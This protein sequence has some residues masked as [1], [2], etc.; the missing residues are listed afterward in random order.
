MKPPTNYHAIVAAGGWN[1][2]TAFLSAK[3]KA[4]ARDSKGRFIPMG[5]MVRWMTQEGMR[6]G[7]VVGKSADGK[8]ISVQENGKSVVA[9]VQPKQLEVVKALIPSNQ[10]EAKQLADAQDW[11]KKIADAGG[12]PAAP[13][14][15]VSPAQAK[16]SLNEE[17]AEQGMGYTADDELIKQL[18]MDELDSGEMGDTVTIK[19]PSGSEISMSEDAASAILGWDNPTPG[20]AAKA[21][22]PDA[23]PKVSIKAEDLSPD[24][25]PQ[26]SPLYVD[27]D[28]FKKVG[29]QAGSNAGGVYEAPDGTRYYVKKAQTEQHAANEVLAA[30]LYKD[31]GVTLPEIYLTEFPDG[32]GPAVASKMIDGLK[33]MF[34]N[35]QTTPIRLGKARAGFAMDAWLSNWD[36]VG[37]EYDNLMMDADQNPVRVDPGGALLYRAMGSPKGGLFSDTVGETETLRDAGMNP[38]AAK[39]FGGMSNQDISDAIAATVNKVDLDK[40]NALI[41]ELPFSSDAIRTDLKAKLKNRKADL[42]TKFNVPAAKIGHNADDNLATD[43][44]KKSISDAAD[45]FLADGPTAKTPDAPDFSTK[46]PHDPYGYTEMTAADVKAGDWVRYDFGYKNKQSYMALESFKPGDKYLTVS[47]EGSLNASQIPVSAGTKLPVYKPPV[48]GTPVPQPVEKNLDG[49]IPTMA[50][51][52]NPGDLIQVKGD[53][54]VELDSKFST[55]KGVTGTYVS[56]MLSGGTFQQKAHKST[57][58]SKLDPE[59]DEYK[60][61]KA[62]S[63]KAPATP[64]DEPTPEPETSK[65]APEITN[66]AFSDQEFDALDEYTGDAHGPINSYLRTGLAHG[67]DP[68]D[69]NALVDKLDTA[70]AKS[71]VQNDS[72]VYRGISDEDFDLEPGSIMHDDGFVSTSSSLE[73]AKEFSK[74]GKGPGAVFEIDLPKG[75]NAVD[76]TKAGLG[77]YGEKEILLNRDSLFE[78]TDV[79]VLADGKKYIKATYLLGGPGAGKPKPHAEEV[80]GDDAEGAPA[81]APGAPGLDGGPGDGDASAAGGLGEAELLAKLEEFRAEATSAADKVQAVNLKAGKGGILSKDEI[82]QSDAAYKKLKE[83]RAQA[84]PFLDALWAQKK[85]DLP[86]LADPDEARWSGVT[87]LAKGGLTQVGDLDEATWDKYRDMYVV[88]DPKTLQHNSSLRSDAPA[89]ASKAWAAKVDKLV[90]QH[91]LKEDSLLY[92]GGAFSPEF[93]ATLTPG[94]VLDDKGF[95]S[96]GDLNDAHFYGENRAAMKPGTKH[97]VF[98]IQVHAGQS[99]TDVG[100]GEYVLPR[101]SKML[102]K[103]VREGDGSGGDANKEGVVYL[104]A[105]LA[106]NGDL[107]KVKAHAGTGSDAAEEVTPAV[108]K[109]KAS[110]GSMKPASELKPGDV[111]SPIGSKKKSVITDVQPTASGSIAVTFQDTNKPTPMTLELDPDDQNTMGLVLHGGPPKP[112]P[113][114]PPVAKGGDDDIPHPAAKI[115][116]VVTSKKDGFSGTVIKVNPNSGYSLVLSKDGSKKLWRKWDTLE[117][118]QDEPAPAPELDDPSQDDPV[119]EQVADLNKKADA[120]SEALAEFDVPADLAAQHMGE[121]TDALNAIADG[122]LQFD[123]WAI[124]K[125]MADEW[126]GGDDDSKGGQLGE[127][128]AEL[129]AAAGVTD[130]DIDEP[131]ATDKLLD[132]PG[133]GAQSSDED[134][135][136]MD[137]PAHVTAAIH[138]NEAM[139]AA[140]L[141]HFGELDPNDDVETKKSWLL[142]ALESLNE[143]DVTLSGPELEAFQ[144]LADALG[145][146]MPEQ[147]KMSPG[148]TNYSVADAVIG[149][150][151]LYNGK[152]VEIALINHSLGGGSTSI[153]ITPV[154]GGTGKFIYVNE[155]S[156]LPVTKKTPKP[157]LPV[158]TTMAL[159]PGDTVAGPG[160]KPWK[161]TLAEYDSG[162]YLVAWESESGTTHQNYFPANSNWDVIAE[163]PD[164][165]DAPESESESSVKLPTKPATEIN[166]GDEITIGEPDYQ[167]HGTVLE[168]NV[169]TA[170]NVVLL[171]EVPGNPPAEYI[172]VP[173]EQATINKTAL[174]DMGD[175]EGTEFV[176][177]T[178]LEEGDLLYNEDSE[179]LGTVANIHYNEDSGDYDIQYWDANGQEKTYAGAASWGQ[180]LVKKGAGTIQTPAPTPDKPQV[181]PASELKAGDLI[182]DVDGDT[183]H[184]ESVEALPNGKLKISYT[185]DEYGDQI[186]TMDIDPSNT[187]WFKKTG[188]GDAPA[189]ETTPAKKVKDYKPGDKVI[190][191][192][193]PGKIG[194]SEQS[195]FQE[196]GEWFLTVDF[197]DGAYD[198]GWVSNNPDGT[199]KFVENEDY[200]DGENITLTP[201]DAPQA[202]TPTAHKVG[203]TP[204]ASEYTPGMVLQTGT[205]SKNKY[206]VNSV[207]PFTATGDGQKKV[208]LNLTDVDSGEVFPSHT[209]PADFTNWELIELPDAPAGPAVGDKITPNQVK[210]GMTIKHMSGVD[211]EVISVAP[212]NNDSSATLHLKGVEDGG[213]FP[214]YVM[215]N[216]SGAW[217]LVANPESGPVFPPLDQKP[218]S[219]PSSEIAPGDIIWNGISTKPLAKLLSK[220]NETNS[221]VNWNIEGVGLWA[222]ETVWKMG[223]LDSYQVAK[224]G[225]APGVPESA[226]E[227]SAPEAPTGTLVAGSS[228]V[229]QDA[230]G[231]YV[232]NKQGHVLREGDKVVT[233]KGE[234]GT[235]SKFELDAKY[236]KVKIDGKTK[237]RQI[238]TLSPAAGTATPA[239]TPADVPPSAVHTG[240]PTVLPPGMGWKLSD[241]VKAPDLVPGQVAGNDK[242]TVEYQKQSAKV[243]GKWELKFVEDAEPLTVSKNNQVWQVW[244]PAIPGKV[245]KKKPEQFQAGEVIELPDG[246]KHEFESLS[247]FGDEPGT[248]E[249][250]FKGTGWVNLPENQLYDVW[251]NGTPAA[252]AG[253]DVTPAEPAPLTHDPVD[254]TFPEGGTASV[255]AGAVIHK[256]VWWSHGKP[257]MADG[258]LNGWEVDP[259]TGE[260]K[261]IGNPYYVKQLNADTELFVNENIADVEPNL[262]SVF[263]EADLAQLHAKIDDYLANGPDS[264]HWGYK[265]Y[266]QGLKTLLDDPTFGE[267]LDEDDWNNA[268]S[269]L[270]SPHVL[271]WENEEQWKQL[272]TE[273]LKARKKWTETYQNE[274]SG[275]VYGGG[276]Y[277][278]NQ[279]ERKALSALAL[280]DNA[281]AFVG[282]KHA[283]PSQNT[284]AAAEIYATVS[285]VS[286]A[287]V[288]DELFGKGT[289]AAI[290]KRMEGPNFKPALSGNKS[291]YAKTAPDLPK[292]DGKNGSVIYLGDNVIAQDGQGGQVVLV[293]PDGKVRVKRSDGTH[294]TRKGSAFSVTSSPVLANKPASA[295]QK[296]ETAPVTLKPRP[297][298]KVPDWSKGNIG[299]LAG[300]PEAL[301]KVKSSPD[302]GTEGWSFAAGG[303]HVEEMDVRVKRVLSKAGQEMV[304]LEFK[305]T[306][307]QG[308]SMFKRLSLDEKWTDSQMQLEK[309]EW[310]VSGALAKLSSYFSHKTHGGR[311]LS[312][313]KS[314]GTQYRLHQAASKKMELHSNGNNATAFHNLVQIRLPINATPADIAKAMH[315]VGVDNPGPAT[316]QDFR[317][318][319]ENKLLSLFAKKT[320]AWV[321][322]DS[323]KEPNRSKL[324]SEIQAKWSVTADDIEILHGING[325]IELRLPQ[326]VADQIIQTNKARYFIHH[327]YGGE[328]DLYTKIGKNPFKALLGSAQ[329]RRDGVGGE[330]GTGMSP[331]EDVGTG[332]ADYVFTR[333]RETMGGQFAGNMVFDGRK[334]ARRMDYFTRNGDK[335]GARKLIMDI[336]TDTNP[337]AGETMFKQ[338]MA[339][340]EAMG[341]FVNSETQRQTL[342]KKLKDHGVTHL[343]SRTVEEFIVVASSNPTVVEVPEVPGIT[344]GSMTDVPVAGGPIA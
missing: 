29:G 149:D 236:A 125:E 269:L 251:E 140:N 68:V 22:I 168:K 299:G 143:A 131:W 244:K 108:E 325:R 224:G 4:Q 111:T 287:A 205:L 259:A 257:V 136:E 343:G 79:S 135:D 208:T 32:G 239:G 286:N 128:W 290:A 181:L 249:I 8:T 132:H 137:Q 258:F 81:G 237:A 167:A 39:I 260:K 218:V 65:V 275:P 17:L 196:F 232:V 94:S 116:A 198:S 285:D 43:A 151:F 256:P 101:S 330:V 35:G 130:Q 221:F 184:I 155:G 164:A 91:Q 49:T 25:S 72:T 197:D 44:D 147:N 41:D 119:K 26:E 279:N 174:S 7:F 336:I 245:G 315:D 335:F 230:K 212:G 112:P 144:N 272:A 306:P 42:N 21:T 14:K 268:Q 64:A 13:K 86:D 266:A 27:T 180:W 277:F 175:L 165:P 148:V 318:L 163:A 58:F 150:E 114:D 313:D 55:T 250:K 178:D 231:K 247:E 40:A 106:P 252:P 20:P 113:A 243:S 67:M 82:A 160:G 322:N 234:T 56:G 146:P 77:G 328:S 71:T 186:F 227:P 211:Y 5:G 213:D 124:L 179:I 240:G 46:P 276:Q 310:S 326:K 90:A 6:W 185:V 203:D 107:S 2:S 176:D 246:T 30:Q 182:L 291:P 139:G 89:P 314:D 120:F 159:K 265:G 300:L 162:S 154:G 192:G 187:T 295:Q 133:E 304:E 204:P 193:K 38:Q 334:V 115:N 66:G 47:N 226:P 317:R 134:A 305:L 45:K 36:S 309:R 302:A 105:E 110:D 50:I 12:K 263:P 340:D 301:E 201:A 15:K 126:I 242:K 121:L 273:V 172:A 142:D 254:F 152:P 102:I 338:R 9:K 85:Q 282:T 34:P 281:S 298:F 78:I 339:L 253:G 280:S 189:A 84:K 210:P 200:P 153:Y 293:T 316:K 69:I 311:T 332:G 74:F 97:A 283:Y 183:G 157:D 16:A 117:V 327:L 267:A 18:I 238:D 220:K 341:Y 122:S 195:S 127:A 158:K 261:S 37:L 73:K 92:R 171:L 320:D 329:R 331:G 312:Y 3:A 93:L 307:Q 169:N 296:V 141:D 255:P 289:S 75:A 31:A 344:I 123:H 223:K 225:G 59:S 294:F 222:G 337:N 248:V 10:A 1:L 170:G 57:K 145:V 61:A 324:L 241:T 104:T 270:M 80:I 274:W 63:A 70:I 161:I 199:V 333:P 319:A 28:G 138:L 53:Q 190:W 264:G 215:Q 321:G 233:K 118:Q 98:E 271:K 217:T 297:E 23:P 209:L 11:A 156:T 95:Q 87:K 96:T 33:P 60:V 88:N 76:V 308:R 207:K 109:T 262:A 19:P 323:V 83:L 191:D 235:I 278:Y 303:A 214:G 173:H 216:I 48:G 103:S 288:I 52:L 177:T 99:V 129:K 229:F 54:I 188:E 292:T 284:D 194:T 342:I 51:N 166:V 62:V 202:P 24:D 228:H 100:Y 206:K 219:T